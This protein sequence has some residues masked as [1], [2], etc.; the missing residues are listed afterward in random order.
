MYLLLK[1]V[2]NTESTRIHFF[3]YFR[4]FTGSSF[5]VAAS[6]SVAVAARK[7]YVAVALGVVAV[8]LPHARV[9][10]CR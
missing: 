1:L 7:K 10:V 6:D 3:L 9:C 5:A 4:A 8:A 2:G